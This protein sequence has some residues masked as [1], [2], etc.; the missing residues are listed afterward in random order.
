VVEPAGL[1]HLPCTGRA[2]V[3]VRVPGGASWRNIAW[4]SSLESGARDEAAAACAAETKAPCCCRCQASASSRWG[5]RLGSNCTAPSSAACR[6]APSSGHSFRR[7]CSISCTSWIPQHPSLWRTSCCMWGWASCG[8]LNCPGRCPGCAALRQ[9]PPKRDDSLL[10]RCMAQA[11]EGRRYCTAP[12]WQKQ[13]F[14]DLHC[15]P[16]H[17]T[18]SPGPPPPSPWSPP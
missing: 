5:L 17:A 2:V 3:R 9:V 18:I 6:W 1:R 13:G 15:V 11:D 4:A 16:V 14:T 12:K 10:S 8:V 7:A